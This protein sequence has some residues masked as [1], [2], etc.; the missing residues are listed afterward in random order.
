MYM[1][2]LIK[3]AAFPLLDV[4]TKVHFDNGSDE[5]APGESAKKQ[6]PRPVASGVCPGGTCAIEVVFNLRNAK[7]M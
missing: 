6:K 1:Q 4:S 5:Y 2:I 3:L 7:V